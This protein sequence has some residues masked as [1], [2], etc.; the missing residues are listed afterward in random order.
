[1]TLKHARS[2]LCLHKYFVY[3]NNT[4]MSE[5][6]PT[7]LPLLAGLLADVERN[8]DLELRAAIQDQL[9]AD[10]Q[11]AQGASWNSLVAVEAVA[12]KKRIEFLHH[13]PRLPR[14]LGGSAMQMVHVKTSAYGEFTT[15]E[16]PP[17]RLTEAEHAGH[18]VRL[19]VVYEITKAKQPQYEDDVRIERYTQ[20]M[21]S[22]I[23]RRETMQRVLFSMHNRSASV[24]IEDLRY[25]AVVYGL[26]QTVLRAYVAENP[27]LEDHLF[28]FDGVL[29]SNHH[30]RD[31]I[32]GKYFSTDYEYRLL[33]KHNP[34]LRE[35]M[36]P[37]TAWDYPEDLYVDTLTNLKIAN[38]LLA[39]AFARSK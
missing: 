18:A 20:E 39:F 9:M 37:G 10:E 16:T 30:I 35:L 4:V 28:T 19:G 29:L 38:Q 24:R 12:L 34:I 15:I 3:A 23:T 22:G 26:K 36:Q 2:G 6:D 7:M 11:T 17:L 25:D 31:D 33:D 1:M 21:D 8:R 13:H 5:V 14:L 32:S 27:E